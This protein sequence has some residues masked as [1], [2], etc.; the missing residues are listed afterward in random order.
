VRLTSGQVLGG[1][2]IGAGIA[3]FAAPGVF[4]S[5]VPEALP[6]SQRTW[7]YGS[8]VVEMAV[9]ASVLTPQSR[10]KGAL[11]AAALFVAVFPGNIKQAVDAETGK[12]KAI[13]YARLPLQV[14]LVVWAL[15]VSR[16]EI[17]TAAGRQVSRD[18]AR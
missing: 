8:G 4:D 13:S 12:E 11:A 14:P 9:G 16:R 2:L 5:L 18:R 10:R 17:S 15:K 3:H 6:G 1:F 7:T